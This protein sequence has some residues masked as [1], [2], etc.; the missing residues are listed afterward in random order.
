MELQLGLMT[1][2]ELADWFGI[3][4]ESFKRRK[5][6]KLEELK[7][8]AEF[9]EE[10]G[11]VMITEIYEPIYQ[12]QL[13][14]TKQ[15]VVNKIDEVWSE[16]GLDSCTRVGNEIC[17]LLNKEGVSRKPDTIIAYTRQGRNELYGKPFMEEG[18]LGRCIYIWCKRD[19]GTGEYSLL[20]EEEQKIKQDLQTK[21]FGD[22]T[23]KQILVKGM[24]EAGE[25]TK[26][27]AWGVLE[28]MTNMGNHNFMA[29][30]R[31]IQKALNCQVVRGT[32]VERNILAIDEGEK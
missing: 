29:F 22:A 18:K 21:F 7:L 11:K 24:V 2:Q 31:E 23:E 26:E 6:D 5:K 17:E 28:E 4:E 8:F 20:T 12:K 19:P 3:K 14:K 25:I 9:Y 16:N 13:G 1:N 27:E 30:L 10:K 15:M 32:L